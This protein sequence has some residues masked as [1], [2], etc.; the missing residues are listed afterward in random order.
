MKA[1]RAALGIAGIVCALGAT[2]L[3][4]AE[5]RWNLPPG[6]PEPLVPEDNPM[7]E[8][9]VAL[10]ALLF[11]DTRLSMTGDYSCASCH[12]PE[13]AF[14]DGLRTAV[15]ATGEHLDRNTPSLFN[16]AYAASLGWADPGTRTLEA[17]HRIPMFNTDPVELGSDAEQLVAALR[18]DEMIMAR[19]REAFESDAL[20]L[21]DVVRAI[22][23]YV[24]SL[25]VADSPFDR[26]LYYDEDV[27]SA[28]AKAG[29]WL[30]FSERLGCATCHAS[31]NLSGPVRSVATPAVAPVFHNTGLYEDYTDVG[32]ARHTGRA[33]DVGAFRAPSLR[34]VART[35]PY[36]HDGSLAT[37]AEV[38]DFYESGGTSHPNQR[39]QIAGFSLEPAQVDALIAFLQALTTPEPR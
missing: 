28:Q 27:L 36:M 30:F 34:N 10:G 33:Q 12:R 17:Q 7:S 23:S 18:T 8:A 39:P 13:L 14:T 6:F 20:T 32:L 9:K 11:E 19:V 35:A 22:A 37:L 5:Y 4:V 15:G 2:D 31:F 16:V 1:A 21:D 3:V 26:Y 25:I 29:M 24:R 38:I